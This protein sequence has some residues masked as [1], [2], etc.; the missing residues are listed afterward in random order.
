MNENEEI[1]QGTYKKSKPRYKVVGSPNVKC[2]KCKKEV[3][4]Q[5]LAGH[6]RFVH[7]EATIPKP[8][9][10]KTVMRKSETLTEW[11]PDP[12]ILAG[13]IAD[14]LLKIFKGNEKKA[15]E[16]IKTVKKQQDVH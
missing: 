14:L 12:M 13:E 4:R 7:K 16:K 6:M 2:P 1:I 9:L 11:L 10:G 15:I 8:Q 3:T 5:G